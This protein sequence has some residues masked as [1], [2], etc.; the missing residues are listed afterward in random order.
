MLRGKRLIKLISNTYITSTDKELYLFSSK[1][2][3][4]GHLTHH[5]VKAPLESIEILCNAPVQ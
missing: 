2:V 1:E 4:E 5:Q 3:C